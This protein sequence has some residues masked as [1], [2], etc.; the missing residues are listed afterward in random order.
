MVFVFLSFPCFRLSSTS[1]LVDDVDSFTGSHADLESAADNLFT[2]PPRP[3]PL[4]FR[5]LSLKTPA[6]TVP[7][8]PG[9]ALQQK[10]ESNL[11]KSQGNTL[12]I[13]L[14]QQMGSFQASVLEAFQSLRDK[15]TTKKQ[16]EVD[17]TSVSASKPGPSTSAVYLDP[18]LPR[19]RTT[20]HVEEIEVLTFIMHRI[21]ILMHL[22]SLLRRPWIDLKNTLTKG[23]RLNRGLPRIN[24]MMNPMDLGSHL[25]NPQKHAD[26]SRHKVRSRY[27]S[28][29]SEEDQSSVT[30]HGSSKPS[31]TRPSG[32]LSD[33]D[34]PQH[35]PD[36]PYYREV[37]LFDVPS[38]YTEEVDTF[39][40]ILSLPDPR[41][42]MPRSSTSVMGLDDGKRP[43]RAQA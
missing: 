11:E 25:L 31:E 18:P 38:Q 4:P 40:R 3:Q 5:S 35:D 29:S 7:P 9:T 24:T 6:K 22:R 36:P 8:T 27:M 37:A 23:M 32:A 33:Q 12:N 42:S 17:Q 39:R 20:S 43:S 30:R 2:S 15:L 14:Q 34:Q 21:R 26:K 19:P 1:F 13:H 16:A 41:E 10:I 28:S